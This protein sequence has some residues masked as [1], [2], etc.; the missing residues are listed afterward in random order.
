MCMQDGYYEKG[1]VKMKTIAVYIQ[2]KLLSSGITHAIT[3]KNPNIS[4]EVIPGVESCLA[5]CRSSKADVL[6]AELRDYYPLTLKDWINRVEK[7]KETIPHCKIVLVV[8]E[9]N[10]PKS[11]AVANR[12]FKNEQI[13]LFLYSSSGLNYLV[14]IVTSV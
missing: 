2:N 3:N 4:V 8:D 5:V 14:D 7:I 11:A 12:A 6:L 13:D 10:F 9:E 1:G